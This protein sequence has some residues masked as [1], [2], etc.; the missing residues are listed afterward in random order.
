MRISSHDPWDTVSW[1]WNAEPRRMRLYPEAGVVCGEIRA[2]FQIRTR[3]QEEGSD[4][5]E[6]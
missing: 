4:V 3:N 2:A 6:V 5:Q 1:D